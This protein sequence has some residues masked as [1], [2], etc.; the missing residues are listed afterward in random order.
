MQLLGILN[1]PFSLII[2]QS[3]ASATATENI[4]TL[5]QDPN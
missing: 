3:V 5:T 4:F 2:D 1:K